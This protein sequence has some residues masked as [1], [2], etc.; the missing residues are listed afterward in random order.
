LDI[1]IKK[2]TVI[3]ILCALAIVAVIILRIPVV[4]FPP[5]FYEPKDVII[6]IGGFLFGP[7]WALIMSLIVAFVEMITISTTGLIGL[8][9]N[10]LSSGTFTCTAAF[11]YKTNARKPAQQSGLPKAVLL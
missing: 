10:V 7:I 11:I 9:M 4:P 8:I 1:N 5:L 2:I 6:L 3:G